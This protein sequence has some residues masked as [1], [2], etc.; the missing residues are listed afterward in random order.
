MTNPTT[1]FVYSGQ[2]LDEAEES[3]ESEEQEEESDTEGED[4]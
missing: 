3:E 2:A 1:F 4:E